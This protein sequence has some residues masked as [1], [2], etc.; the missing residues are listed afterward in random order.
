MEKNYYDNHFEQF[1][2]ESVDDFR[3]YPSRK[4]WTSIYNNIQPGR[5]W[6]SLPIMLLMLMTFSFLGS[7]NKYEIRKFE[8]ANQKI[9]F[10]KDK[11]N[12]AGNHPIHSAGNSATKMPNNQA[13][14]AQATLSDNKSNNLILD[15]ASQQTLIPNQTIVLASAKGKA[16]LSSSSTETLEF[17]NDAISNEL[18]E[19]SSLTINATVAENYSTPNNISKPGQVSSEK[20]TNTAFRDGS[21]KEDFNQYDELTVSARNQQLLSIRS[22]RVKKRSITYLSDRETIEDIAFHNKPVNKWKGRA[23][24][25]FY[26]TPSVGYR[27]LNS[28]METKNYT[29][30]LSNGTAGIVSE[31]NQL[32]HAPG[33]NLELGGNYFYRLTKNLRLKA[34]IQINYTNYRIHAKEIDHP[35]MTM[36]LVNNP[37]T[38]SQEL[39]SCASSLAN[40]NGG[41]HLNSSTFQFSFPIG[42]DLKLAGNEDFQWMIGGTI[43]PTLVMGGNPYL[44]SA[45]MKNY[46]NDPSMLRRLNINSSIE[47]FLS[48]RMKNGA[49]LNAGP[50]FRYQLLSTY[51]KQYVYDEKLYNIGF[52]I[53]ISKNL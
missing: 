22:P 11:E 25:T 37:T 35:T 49:T 1:L 26:A 53:G 43:Q 23:G 27:Q 15:Q 16:N 41:T 38:G 28:T 3:M 44:V 9:N 30:T 50:Q 36:L 24:Y 52:K 10:E 29:Q 40:V 18:E 4:V 14:Y 2:K 33:F 39:V 12:I 17:T 34:G 46:I 21:L 32:D 6:P 8:A 45:D 20:E 47:T 13:S 51:N 31:S 5:R 7:S 19:N 48:Y 42:A